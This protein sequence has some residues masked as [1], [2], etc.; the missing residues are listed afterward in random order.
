MPLLR[1]TADLD[2]TRLHGASSPLLP[3]L[4]RAL[5]CDPGPV[6]VMIHGF[7]YSPG[8][9]RHC[10]HDSIFA[11]RPRITGA[12][13]LSWPRHLGLRGQPGAGL[14]LSFGWPARGTIWQAFER[15][16]WAGDQLAALLAQLQRLAPTRPVHLIAHSLGAR[17]ALRAVAQSAPGT[18]ARMILLAGA[19]FIPTAQQALSRQGTN[20][21]DLPQVL[22]VTSRENDLFDFLLER[23]I[24]PPRP[25]AR[26]LGHGLGHGDTTQDLSRMA[27]L[28]LDDPAALAALRKAGFPIAA[29][30][31]RICHWS[32]YLRPGVFPLYRAFL[33]GALEYQTLCHILPNQ[34]AARW[35]RL[36][37]RAPRPA[38]ATPHRWHQGAA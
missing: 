33:S 11:T 7:K 3:S 27:T 36:M 10:P 18:V 8:D 21:A 25:G 37:P 16:A 26:V 19:E 17:V 24:P 1:I 20:P 31:R 13:V 12:R 22:N 2:G 23:M 32:P 15:A 29:A 35:S 28:Q 38:Q 9:P 14:G 4:R 5:A 34:T 6:T 30:T